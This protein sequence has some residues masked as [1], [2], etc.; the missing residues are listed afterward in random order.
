[1]GGFGQK[2]NLEMKLLS[3][4]LALSNGYEQLYFRGGCNENNY[5]QAGN[6]MACATHGEQC[7]LDQWSQ[8]RTNSVSMKP[9][10]QSDRSF[11][12]MMTAKTQWAGFPDA[13]DAYIGMLRFDEKI[14][15]A[16]L[17]RQMESGEVTI[18]VGDMVSAY[19]QVDAVTYSP[20]SSKNKNALMMQFKKNSTSENDHLLQKKKNWDKFYYS[21]QIPAW[22]GVE[23]DQ[24]NACMQKAWLYTLPDDGANGAVDYTKCGL[25]NRYGQNPD[26]TEFNE[27]EFTTVEPTTVLRSTWNPWLSDETQAGPEKPTTAESEFE[28]LPDH[29]ETGLQCSSNSAG[30]FLPPNRIVGGSVVPEGTYPWQV[31]V[32]AAGGL[33]GGSILSENWIITAAHCCEIALSPDEVDI[34]IADRD[35]WSSAEDNEF[36]VTAEEII[37]H[38]FYGA[39]NSISNDICLLKVPT[40]ATK[41]PDSCDGCYAAICLPGVGD[42]TP[43]GKACFVSGWG[44][45]SSQGQV[46]RY[47]QDVSVNVL[48]YQ[49]CI[50]HSFLG[51]NR[52]IKGRELCAAIP[53]LDGD[54]LLDGGKDSCQGDSGGPLTC[55]FNKQP[56]LTGIVSWGIGCADK[57][58]P[59]V[60][61]DVAEYVE[62]IH[63]KCA[64]SGVPLA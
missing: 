29:I 23:L 43:H 5:N 40:L 1:M 48:D 42:S 16:K 59:G 11:V 13:N 28:Q 10:L 36:R 55:V 62:W 64:E 49:Y 47:L 33:C 45:T 12:A 38:P 7:Q 24:F 54:G 52:L 15:G 25:Y 56:I 18:S 4:F 57:G 20:V 8:G 30:R 22:S 44:T 26:W 50:D 61:T 21:G 3:S 39:D 60:Y 32:M 9:I 46:S 58:Q 17:L 63:E 31:R 34:I 37:M 51:P 19:Y 27:S 2:R 35:L 6:T 53:D 41:K 14:C